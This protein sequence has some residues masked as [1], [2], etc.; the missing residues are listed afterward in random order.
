VWDPGVWDLGVWDLGACR[1]VSLVT[2]APVHDSEWRLIASLLRPHRRALAGYGAVLAVAAGLALGG[3]LLL[4]RFV[5]LAVDRAPTSELVAVIVGY[6]A[7]GLAASVVTVV[8]TWRSITLAW[9]ITDSLRHEL[10]HHVLHADL[11]FHRDR[12][13]G[14]LV[15]RVDADVTAMTQFLSQVVARI[16]AIAVLA[17]AAVVVLA[18]V[19]PVL[20][21]P[22]ALGIGA[23]ALVT[24]VQRDSATALTAAE[25]E[26]EAEVMAVTEQTLAGADDLAA[27]GAGAY[28]TA[29]LG[30]RSAVLVHAT[31]RRVRAQMRVQAAIRTTIVAAE[32]FVVG[33][34][35]WAAYRGWISIGAVFLGDRFVAVVRQ[36]VENLTWRLQDA[37][38]AAG[39]AR[40]VLDLLAERREVAR[41]GEPLPPGPVDVVFEGVELAYDDEESEALAVHRIDLRLPA[42]RSLGLIGRSGSGKTSIARLALRLVAPTSGRVLV[43][44][45][46]LATL[47]ED[48]LRARVTAVPQDVQLFPGT[49]RDNVTLFAAHDDAAVVDGLVGVGLGPW[50]AALPAGLDARLGGDG[51][52]PDGP[53]ARAGL[54]AGQAQL[55]A[56]ARALLHRPD[57]VVLDEATSRVDPET[58]RAIAQATAT[59]V[60]GRTCLMI[61]H[62]LE[63]LEVCDDIAVMADGRLVE[64]GPRVELAADPSSRYAQLL[65]LGVEDLEVAP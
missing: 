28:G 54:S 37:Q 22:L 18:V 34:G 16:V 39:A 48:E 38:G 41:G 47:D 63:T 6:I 42:G 13:P 14:E 19:E 12:T 49:V 57:V 27:L 35:A 51:D 24:W 40:R 44:G 60:R 4:A 50:L 3:S 43:G 9:R 31:G 21:A 29:R 45:R 23:I 26:A 36:P 8:V 59:L 33:V 10:A 1:E 30:L 25:R 56:M 7:V 5:D 62:R 61:A 11:A 64:H 65:A 53:D 55:L 58:Q 20:A 15:T 2:V 52:H 32:A 46:D 17:V